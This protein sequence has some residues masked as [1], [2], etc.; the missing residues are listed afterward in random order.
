M[1]DAPVV[2]DTRERKPYS[3]PSIDTVIY[4][5]LDVGDYTR[6]GYRDVFAVERKT[7]DD[8]A[9]SLGY[10]RDRF[11]SEIERA[12]SLD[13]FVV[14]IEADKEAVSRYSGEGKG[15][16]PN[17]FSDIAPNSVLGTVRSWPTDYDPLRFEWCG[18]RRNGMQRTLELLDKWYMRYNI[19]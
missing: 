12:Q 15:G 10:E 17:Y 19:S 13:E 6:D 9:T 2:I 3:F 7:L 16:C 1:S 5:R 8:L 14:V 11:R 18:D 4:D